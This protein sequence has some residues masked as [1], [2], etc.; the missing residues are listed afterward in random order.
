M[1]LF[2]GEAGVVDNGKVSKER[3]NNKERSNRT[4]EEGSS[5]FHSQGL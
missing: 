5:L 4:D 1:A 2:W 3:K